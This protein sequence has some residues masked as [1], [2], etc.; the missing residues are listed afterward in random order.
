MEHGLGKEEDTIYQQGYI[1]LYVH[2]EWTELDDPF[3]LGFHDWWESQNDWVNQSNQHQS[4]GCQNEQSC[5]NLTQ[6]VSK[7]SEQVLA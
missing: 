6:Q 4:W 7:S 2:N 5:C 3:I 1:Y